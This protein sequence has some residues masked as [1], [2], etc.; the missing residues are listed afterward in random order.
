M[1]K[2][3]LRIIPLGGLGEIGKNITAIEYEDEIIVIDCGI[4]FPDEDMYGIDLVIPD[5]KYLLDNKDKVKGLFLT[6]GHED[7]IGAIPYILKQIN[8][9]VYGTKLTI[10]L[11][12]SKLKEH[13][14]LSK[15][16]LIPISPGESIKLNKLI[17]EFI[18]VTHSIAESCALAIHTPIGI[19]LHT[20]DF[21]ID[22][23]PIDGKV[24]DLNRIAQLGQEGIL[25]LMADSTNVERAGHSLS[26]K[27]IGETLNRIISNANGRVIVATFASN[28]HRMQQIAD[29]SMM[30]NRKNSF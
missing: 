16:N 26:E 6:H 1:R 18:R 20:G 10:G 8:M 25:L 9:P 19:V 3:S 7:H 2:E 12:E 27:I 29:A 21:K 13:D 11:V 28:I 17:I 30:Y 15:T 24:M 4:S 14:M 23:T 5:I 22:Y